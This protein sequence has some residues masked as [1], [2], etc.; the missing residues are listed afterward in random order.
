MYAK[1]LAVHMEIPMKYCPRMK[2]YALRE[3]FASMCLVLVFELLQ[4][5]LLQYSISMEFAGC[6]GLVKHEK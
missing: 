3:Q 6:K 1:G 2:A 4:F 5:W